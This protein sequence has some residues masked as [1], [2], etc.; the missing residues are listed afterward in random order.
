MVVDLDTPAIPPGRHTATGFKKI[1]SKSPR[2]VTP[3]IVLPKAEG[4]VET[5]IWPNNNFVTILRPITWPYMR[6]VYTKGCLEEGEEEDPGYGYPDRPGGPAAN[7]TAPG[8]NPPGL[9]LPEYRRI[10]IVGHGNYSGSSWSSYDDSR[11]KPSYSNPQDSIFITDAKFDV[12]IV[13]NTPPKQGLTDSLGRR[14]DFDGLPFSKIKFH[15][16]FRH[17]FNNAV[18]GSIPIELGVGECTDVRNYV[19]YLPKSYQ[20]QYPIIFRNPKG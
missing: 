16:V 13:A 14:C 10:T 2:S 9:N 20:T 15:L 18:L 3:I 4:L 11:F 7:C 19:D 17:S 6:T 1:T 5:A 12:R 8:R